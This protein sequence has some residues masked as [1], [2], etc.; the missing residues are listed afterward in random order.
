[1]LNLD[2]RQFVIAV[3]DHKLMAATSLLSQFCGSPFG[4]RVYTKLLQGKGAMISTE[5]PSGTRLPF[6]VSNAVL[7]RELS[8][9]A[10]GDNLVLANATL[11]ID[12]ELSQSDIGISGGKFTFIGST[13]A[14]LTDWPR[15]DLANRLCLPSFVDPHT[16]LDKGHV[17]GRAGAGDGTLETAIDLI[18]KDRAGNW[19]SEDVNARMAFGL[20]CA[21]HYGT[22]ALRT[23]IDSQP[24][25]LEISWGVF[26]RLRN[27]WTDKLAL[28]GSSLFSIAFARDAAFIDTVARRVARAGGS[29]GAVTFPLPDLDALLDTMFRAA[30]RHGLSLDFHADETSDTASDTLSRIAAACLRHG[31]KN[32]VVAG[33]CCSLALQDASERDRTL[34]LV[35]EAEIGLICLPACN[36]YL[37]DRRFDGTTPR[38]RGVTA[39]KEARARGIN[40]ALGSDNTRDPFHPFGDLDMLETLGLGVRALHLDSPVS[41]WVD[42]VTVKPASM[43]GIDAGKIAV[44]QRAD[45]TIFEGRDFTEVLARREPDRIVMRDGRSMNA[46]LPSYRELDGPF[47]SK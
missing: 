1:M 23:H 6:P 22:A 39:F 41:A 3:C 9:L 26:E 45:F 47:A 27:H 12:G 44:G 16:H 32:N 8:S 43:L 5:R 20:A 40:V 37:Q 24:D 42:A 11:V 34:D 38:W 17:I 31:M 33:H 46:A 10:P 29:L 14:T 13:P 36:L 35:A 2:L 21:Y 19:S 15:I 28:Y 7:S 25:Q 30:D 18:S 4:W